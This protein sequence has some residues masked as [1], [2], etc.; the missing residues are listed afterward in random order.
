MDP[1]K[2]KRYKKAIGVFSASYLIFVSLGVILALGS[3]ARGMADG[4]TSGPDPSRLAFSSFVMHLLFLTM[5]LSQFWFLIIKP[6]RRKV[7]IGESNRGSS[8]Y[9]LVVSYLVVLAVV[10]L[11]IINYVVSVGSYYA[12]SD[13][14]KTY[15]KG[16]AIYNLEL[17][18]SGLSSIATISI[19]FGGLPFILVLGGI[20]LIKR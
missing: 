16:S 20:Y 5:F 13:S 15:P 7:V 3:L 19:F 2:S 6:N 1:Q 10:L 11:T 8:Y 18:L 9:K 4:V 12:G 17:L 14:W